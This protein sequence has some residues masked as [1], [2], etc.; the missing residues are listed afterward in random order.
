[1]DS[2]R[3][4]R[5][6]ITALAAALATSGLFAATTLAAGSDLLPDLRMGAIFQIQLDTWAN[7]RVMLRFGTVVYNDGE[8]AME[9]RGSDRDG[10]VMRN[11]R[12]WIYS[13]DGTSRGI[14]KDVRVFYAGDGHTHWHV[15]K[16]VVTKL[17][18]LPGTPVTGDRRIR[19][20]GFCLVDS[21]RQTPEAPTPHYLGCGNKSST[22]VKVGTDVGWG[23]V[24]APSTKYQAIDVTTA[25]VGSYRLCA[26]VNSNFVWTEKDNNFTNNQAWLDIDLDVPNNSVSIINSGQTACS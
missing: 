3:R 25:P 13:S 2:L 19:K 24:Y 9:V 14:T 12:Q 17:K 8:G 22:S 21:V 23:D 11:V 4:L 5:F 18:P 20:I 26:T 15:N 1:V 10:N 16:Y 7:G 6:L